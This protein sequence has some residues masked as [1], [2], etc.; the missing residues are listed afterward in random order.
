M[1]DLKVAKYSSLKLP[2]E[3]PDLRYKEKN[4][5]KYKPVTVKNP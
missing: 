3:K 2:K 4:E 1:P 5:L